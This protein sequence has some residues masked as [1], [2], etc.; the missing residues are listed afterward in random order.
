MRS[1]GQL[2]L[3]L[4]LSDVEAQ[5]Q[6][7]ALLRDFST[8]AERLLAQNKVSM[9]EFQRMSLPIHLRSDDE[10]NH[11]LA[12]VKDVFITQ[13]Y[14]DRWITVPA[15]SMFEEGTIGREAY[16]KACFGFVASLARD[17]MTQALSTVVSS[18]RLMEITHSMQAEFQQVVQQRPEQGKFR[19]AVMRL[20]RL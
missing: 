2:V 15:W 1:G 9:E 6:G 20:E 11:A 3:T 17:W 4:L 7:C 18:M 5:A 19:F 14:S 12:S 13:E 16:A 10:V 8:A